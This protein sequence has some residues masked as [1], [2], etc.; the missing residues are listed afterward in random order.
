ML[1]RGHPSRLRFTDVQSKSPPL[2]LIY[3]YS[4]VIWR[5]SPSVMEYVKC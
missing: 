2:R 1:R 4:T 5:V 3:F